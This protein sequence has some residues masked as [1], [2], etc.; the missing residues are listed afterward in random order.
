MT[1][2]GGTIRTRDGV[3][4]QTI[5]S[6]YPT[7][8]TG[9]EI[10]R[11]VGALCEAH[12]CTLTVDL[13]MV[14]FST[15]PDSEG[16]QALVGTYNEYTGRNDRPFTIGGGTYARHFKAGGAFGPNDPSFPMPEWVGAEHSADE[17]FSEE[18][19]KRALEIYIVSVARLMR[20]SF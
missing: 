11:R 13:D 8:I 12:G 14:P 18:Q 1:C 17:G 7:S 20:L 6:R 3:F 9:E 5:D 2:I 4:E 19:F 10:A 16:V 15:D